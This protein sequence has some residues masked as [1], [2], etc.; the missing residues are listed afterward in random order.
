MNN[1]F[2]FINVTFARDY[3]S[4][5]R[6]YWIVKNTGTQSFVTNHVILF[7]FKIFVYFKFWFGWFQTYLIILILILFNIIGDAYQ[8][9]VYCPIHQY[10]FLS[11]DSC[12]KK[13]SIKIEPVTT[14]AEISSMLKRARK[15]RA[16]AETQCNERSSRSHSVFML[17]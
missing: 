6:G 9:I 13:I 17:R 7:E 5:G 1:F 10:L 12:Q 4:G 14:E 11:F 8:F 3:Y 15:H 16:V 2:L